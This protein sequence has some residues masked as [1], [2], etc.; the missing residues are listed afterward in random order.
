MLLTTAHIGK[1][2]KGVAASHARIGSAIQKFETLSMRITIPCVVWGRSEVAI[3][4]R[5]HRTD[6]TRGH[7][8]RIAALHFMTACS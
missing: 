2:I 8:A 7:F 4:A 1:N 6:Q 5:C 3:F